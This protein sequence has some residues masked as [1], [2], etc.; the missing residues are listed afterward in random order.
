MPQDNAA[1]AGTPSGGNPEGSDVRS[2]ATQIEGL[3]DDSGNY[4]PE[5]TRSRAHPDYDHDDDHGQGRDDKGRFKSRQ[6]DD[7][8]DDDDDQDDIQAA[9]DD[10]RTDDADTGD[11]DDDQ[12]AS[13][14]Q[15]ADD[16][17]ADTD[18]TI[19]SL[20]ELAEAM[21]IPFEELSSELTH[22]FKA[23]GEEV[24]VNLAELVAGYQ[25]DADY[26]RSTA[27]LADSRRALEA[28]NMARIQTFEMSN[29]LLAQQ[30]TVAEQLL[31][32][33]ADTPAMQEL[34]NTD[35]AEW[36]ARRTELGQRLQ[37][38][39]DARQQAAANYQQ[40]MQGNFMQ[41]KQQGMAALK[42][43]IPDF[44]D[45]HIGQVKDVLN[46]F[47][48]SEQEIGQVM[49]H[50]AVLAALEIGQLRAEVAELK[51]LK[52][53]ATKAVKKVKKDVPKMQK[54]GK[55]RRSG[56]G[57]QRD[58]VAKL[59]AKAKKTGSVNDAAKVIE[60]FL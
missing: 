46:S 20:A 52:D 26:R 40:V 15:D 4:N 56:A 29:Q 31:V 43:A 47:G 7:N 37:T 25:K 53:N 2:V 11:T 45:K 5:G 49:D 30:L 32:A 27:E 22:T 48:Y 55:Q 39:R 24:T 17:D 12:V 6:Q 50:R 23:A 19:K 59:A 34:R 18:D 42:E 35:P 51:A 36:Q 3:L 9:A 8:A 28:E 14:S 41:Q 57:I 13:G 16:N 44:G 21:E 38:L 58:N 33:E 10:D 1:Q 60:Q 54:P